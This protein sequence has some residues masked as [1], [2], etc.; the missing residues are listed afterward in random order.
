LKER[1]VTIEQFRNETYWYPVIWFVFGTAVAFSAAILFWQ[2]GSSSAEG[3]L[4]GLPFTLKLTGAGALFVAVL[5]VFYIINPIKPFAD[6]KDILILYSTDAHPPSATEAKVLKID[7]ANLTVDDKSV[8]FDVDQ[9]VIQLVPS[10]FLYTLTPDTSGNVFKTDKPIPN[11]NYYILF[12]S[13]Q[14]GVVKVRSLAPVGGT[15]SNTHN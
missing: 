12:R 4:P 3:K 9:L 7:K 15:D 2:K 8:P 10:D 11:G 6:Y 13:A 14:T 1:T 5:V